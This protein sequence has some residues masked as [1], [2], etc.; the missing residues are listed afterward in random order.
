M[1]AYLNRVL[2]QM[3]DEV[4]DLKT[5]DIHRDDIVNKLL[6]VISSAIGELAIGTPEAEVDAEE[7]I[8]YVKERIARIDELTEE[9]RKLFDECIAKTERSPELKFCPISGEWVRANFHI[10]EPPKK[11]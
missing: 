5:G 2:S 11:Q 7:T 9:N 4:E 8:E 1:N 10:T 3:E 6:T